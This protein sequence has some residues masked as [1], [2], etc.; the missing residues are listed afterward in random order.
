MPEYCYIHIPFCRRKCFY[1]SF[2]SI[3]KTD[4]LPKY[5]DSLHFEIGSQYRNEKLKTLYIGGGT[6]SLVDV[7]DIGGIVSAFKYS[8]H[9][10]ITIELNP[11]S[12]TSYFLRGLYDVG[13]NRISIGVQSFNDKIL[14]SIGRLHD[15]KMALDTMKMAQK[16][17]FNNI[18]VDFIYGLPG[19]SLEMFLSDLRVAVELDVSHISLYGLKIE[20][21]TLFGKNTPENIAD[22]DLQ[23]DMYLAALDLLKSFGFEHYEV[24]NFSKSENYSRHNMNY[25]NCGEYYGFGASAHGY[26]DGVRYVNNSDVLSYIEFPCEKQSSQILSRQ[27]M[28]E[29][30]V[31]LGFRRASG[32]DFQEFKS[33][34]DLDFRVK[35][36]AQLQKYKDFFVI[37]DKGCA[38]TPDGFLVSNVIL[39]DFLED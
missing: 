39:A 13:V 3:S 17:G 30:A 29:E 2:T 19:Q 33:K 35:Y 18:S 15:S 9:P 27:E 5:L 21:E 6:P 28:I 37:T 10:E 36:S 14:D 34:F 22:G 38:F 24:S 31:F 25:W 32:I 23:A 4:L 26:V 1:C 16:L 7:E 12:T 20:K 11:E 8:E